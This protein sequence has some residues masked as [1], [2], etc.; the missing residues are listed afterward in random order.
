MF[1]F[2]DTELGRV[3]ISPTI[4]RRFILNEVEQSKCFRL[5]GVKSG[6]EVNRKTIERSIRV[7]FVEGRAE[8][9]LTLNVLYGT[10]ITKEAR[11]LQ[12][13]IVRAL[14]LSTG[15][16]VT[17][18]SINV[19]NVYEEEEAANPPLLLEHDMVKMNAVNQ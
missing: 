1:G 11:E 8:A 19:E 5:A 17:T 4:V 12:G 13:K 10:R 14:Q 9:I 16:S 18:I 7:N 2:F 6:E 3:Q 15:L